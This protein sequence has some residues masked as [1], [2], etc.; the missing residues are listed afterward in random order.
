MEIQPLARVGSVTRGGHSVEV[1]CSA[2]APITGLAIFAMKF[3]TFKM[4]ADRNCG[5]NDGVTIDISSIL[6]VTAFRVR[7]FDSV[8]EG[9]LHVLS[10]PWFTYFG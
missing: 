1:D 9:E 5:E 6:A 3:L 4:S 2:T 8:G 10:S 7:G